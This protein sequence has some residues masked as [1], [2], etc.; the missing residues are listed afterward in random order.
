MT[1]YCAQCLVKFEQTSNGQEFCVPKCREAYL[2]ELKTERSYKRVTLRSHLPTSGLPQ[3]LGLP[4]LSDQPDGR[5][6][7]R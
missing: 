4:F 3:G 7:N 1:S 6:G 5:Y 2:K